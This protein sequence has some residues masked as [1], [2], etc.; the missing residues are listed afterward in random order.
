MF[1]IV[2]TELDEAVPFVEAFERGFLAVDANDDDADVH[3]VH[4]ELF[5]HKDDIAVLERGFH[6]IPIDLERKDSVP[7]IGKEG[8]GQPLF[9]L[10]RL[11]LLFGSGNRTQQ[12]HGVFSRELPGVASADLREQGTFRQVEMVFDFPQFDRIDLSRSKSARKRR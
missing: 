4:V 11:P 12:R 9:H 8:I 5:V 10:F 2:R 3:I 6:A 7:G 1:G